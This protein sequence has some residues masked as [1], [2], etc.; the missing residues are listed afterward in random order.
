MAW[1]RTE[2]PLQIVRQL[3]FFLRLDQR[4]FPCSSYFCLH[5]YFQSIPL[6]T[7]RTIFAFLPK[8]PKKS[9]ILP[10]WCLLASI[11]ADRGEPEQ[12]AGTARP[13]NHWQ[14]LGMPGR[15]V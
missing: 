5:F 1:V 13:H 7:I 3:G 12:G 4:H 2:N 11:C 9:F 6:S 15:A 8:N 14:A 10:L